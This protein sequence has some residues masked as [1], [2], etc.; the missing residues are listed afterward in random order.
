ML[1]FHIRLNSPSP[2]SRFVLP[3]RL[4][5]S[6]SAMPLFGSEGFYE[7]LAAVKG[8]IRFLFC[9]LAY[10]LLRLY[11]YYRNF[12]ERSARGRFPCSYSG[13]SLYLSTVISSST[14][15]L[16]FSFSRSSSCWSRRSSVSFSF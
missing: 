16:S 14:V 13:I 4:I 8:N 11:S 12:C 2:E 10:L 9:E 5:L 15:S 6:E 7:L 3:M 1:F